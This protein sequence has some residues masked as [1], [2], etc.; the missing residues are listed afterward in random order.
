MVVPPTQPPPPFR[1]RRSPYPFFALLLVVGVV[2]GYG[3]PIVMQSLSSSESLI[4]DTP[5]PVYPIDDPTIFASSVTAVWVP[6]Q[7]AAWY[8]VQLFEVGN[9]STLL[10]SLYVS[11]PSHMFSDLA[12][13]T[14]GWTV[15]AE[16]KDS[17]GDWSQMSFFSV[18]T[19]LEE[20]VPIY[21]V[22][23]DVVNSTEVH[24]QWA[25]T[26]GADRYE[27]QI[28]PT[29]DFDAPLIEQFTSGPSYLCGYPLSNGTTYYWR[30]MA[31]ESEISS[32]WSAVAA[33]TCSQENTSTVAEP[34]HVTWNWTFPEDGSNWSY[35]FNVTTSEY[36]ACRALVRNDQMPSDY[37][38][39]ITDSNSVV[40]AIASYL[41]EE[42]RANNMTDYEAVWFALSFVHATT[43]V[44]DIESTGYDDYA[45]YP[46]ETL[47]DGVG[48]CEDT[49]AL[50]TSIVRAMGYD[51][52]MLYIYAIFGA[53]SNHMGAAVGG[54]AMPQGSYSIMF[55]GEPYYYCETTPGDWAPG[56]L[57]QGL[58]GASYVVVS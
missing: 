12:D 7:E 44:S 51:T 6:V 5:T 22:G 31:F 41:A 58:V 36:D 11:A 33:F 52:V 55:G 27:L 18:R 39:Y 32:P 10:T 29:R 4:L 47:V 42:A 9:G 15:R 17:Q 23:S 48:D 43:Y 21:P 1:R 34:I 28:S 38:K 25:A 40:V 13:G 3:S 30:V 56:E 53:S 54:I 49:A 26:S 46:V 24:F 37:S 19:S 2:L 14:Y 8:Y 57:P 35:S 20:P 50:F 16:A 45:R